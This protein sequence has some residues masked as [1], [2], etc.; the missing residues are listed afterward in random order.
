MG[1]LFRKNQYTFEIVPEKIG[2]II[3]LSWVFLLQH[4][5]EFSNKNI[6]GGIYPYNIWKIGYLFRHR[7]TASLPYRNPLLVCENEK[8]FINSK[9]FPHDLRHW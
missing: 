3:I 1:I 9:E 7:V 2:Y 5:V 4:M 6:F 8:G